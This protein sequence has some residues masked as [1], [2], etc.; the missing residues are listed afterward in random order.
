MD[1]YKAIVNEELRDGPVSVRRCTDLF[2]LVVFILF[3]LSMFTVAGIGFV[4]GNP[5]LLLY[6]YDSS[7]NQCGRPDT[8]TSAYNY[9]YYPS[10]GI[11]SLEL[12]S[13]RVCLKHCPMSNTTSISCYENSEVKCPFDFFYI[14]SKNIKA[15]PYQSDNLWD[16]F[17]VPNSESS[18]FHGVINEI[19]SDNIDTWVTDVFRC[20]KAI[21]I[22]LGIACTLSILYLILMRYCAEIMIWVIIVFTAVFIVAFGI[23]IEKIAKENYSEE[24]QK[25]TH[26]AL[27]I[28]A[29]IIYFFVIVF[30]GIV[31]FMYRRIH[32]AIAI[33]KSGAIFIKDVP[34]ILLVPLVMFLLFCGFFAY[35]VLA[36]FYIYS[37]GDLEKS[38]SVIAKISWDTITRNSMYFEVIGIVWVNSIK[39]AITQFIIACSVS[40]WYFSQ[41]NS[42]IHIISKS[43][44]YA[45]RYHLGTFAF[46]SFLLSLIKVVK[47]VLWYID[48]IIYKPNFQGNSCIKFGC[49]CLECYVNCFTRF[50]KFLDKN[51]Y[52]QTAL[53]GAGFCEAAKNA[54]AIILENAL[55]FAALGAIGDIFKVLGKAFI[56]VV[57]T[58]AGFLIISNFD[59]FQSQIES[60]I[61]PTCVFALSS[62]IVSGLFMTIHE[63]ACDTIIQTF[64]IDE[65]IHK[66]A[67]FAPEPLKDFIKE[68]R[69]IEH[70]SYC[71]GFL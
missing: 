54:Y 39:I 63:M 28:A 58:Y 27:K 37:S 29:L 22:V 69:D 12:S 33:M 51:A 31:V 36:V 56:T 7:G 45:F 48:E 18:F 32:L 44:H 13:Y 34:S 50:I 17:C 46:G 9:L 41:D 49:L 68:N 8:V 62:Y 21:I 61:A 42:S 60:P 20:W 35:W 47:Y 65:Q 4:Q 23:Y 11:D 6:P 57:S 43:V 71:C 64:L 26:D 24:R 70:K 30:A 1:E 67:F 2:F 15:Y 3:L 5:S 66:E 10:G 55:R 53:T 52:I 25:K 14:T 59:P 40:F 16:R 38:N 19:Y